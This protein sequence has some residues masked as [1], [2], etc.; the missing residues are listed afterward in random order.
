MRLA[1]L[2]PVLVAVVGCASDPAC[3]DD[4]QAAPGA[5]LAVLETRDGVC[6]VG[7]HF[8]GASQAPGVLLLHMTPTGGASRADWT[9]ALLDPLVEAGFHVLALDRR[10]A[11]DSGGE[12]VD[13][14][15]GEW[16]RYD[17]E[18]GALF[19]QDNAGASFLTVV[20]ASNGTTSL[21]DYAVWAE[22]ENRP[23]VTAGVLLSGGTY[24][25]N[26]TAMEDVAAAGV[27]LHLAVA[28]SEASW[29]EDHAALDPS[30]SL[31]VRTGSSHGTALLTEH[32]EVGTDIT[33]WLS[34]Q[35]I[36]AEE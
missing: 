16:G 34:A 31:D 33:G 32:P 29:S 23:P 15:E 21:V 5:G 26:Q 17:V 3:A 19:L 14:Y 2:L 1:L 22:G 6:L 8:P 7:D 20:G 11:G 12:G 35:T 28:E 27:P 36:P 30:W 24:T 18:A 13:A 25:E 4:A 9:G 10:G